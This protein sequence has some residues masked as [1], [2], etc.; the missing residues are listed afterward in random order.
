MEAN[1]KTQTQQQISRK[2]V[3]ACGICT[4]IA[5]TSITT[6]IVLAFQVKA[7]DDNTSVVIQETV[8]EHVQTTTTATIVP[9]IPEMSE[10][11]TTAAVLSETLNETTATEV[12]VSP[13]TIPGLELVT[14]FDSY[15]EPEEV[16]YEPYGDVLTP[17]AGTV[18]GPSGREVYYSADMSLC[19]QD[20]WDMGFSGDFY[21]RY[22]GVQ[23]FGDYVM[24]AANLDYRPKGT[25]VETSLGT[26]IVVDGCEAAAWEPDLVDV[27]VTW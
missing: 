6:A 5:I 23:M 18:Q 26:G 21:V 16:V 7:Y 25:I 9:D 3:I 4:G 2:K 20:M 10:P 22:D 13:Q 17:S 14:T 27:S 24:V 15:E 19:V 1:R 11:V 12:T 8:T